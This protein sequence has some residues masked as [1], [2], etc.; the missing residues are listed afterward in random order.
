[1]YKSS[2]LL[3]MSSLSWLT[4][5]ALN[6]KTLIYL[7]RHYCKFVQTYLKISE[8]SN[9]TFKMD[10]CSLLKCCFQYFIIRLLLNI[11]LLLVFILMSKNT[12]RI[13]CQRTK[14]PVHLCVWSFLPLL[15][16]FGRWSH[17]ALNKWTECVKHSVVSCVC[18]SVC[19]HII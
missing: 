4:S 18:A 10:L 12:V 7:L 8:Y 13:M 16:A 2:R 14:H 3:S 5:N 19:T 1:M 17:S 6:T 11:N 9:I 15:S